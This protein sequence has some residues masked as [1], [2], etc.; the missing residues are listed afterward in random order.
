MK[1]SIGSKIINGPW[2]GGNLFVINLSNYLIS[3]GHQVI[4]DLTQNDIDII[5]LTDPRPKSD[6]TSKFNH[7][8][9]I[10]YKKFVNP[11][12][13]VVQRI[14]EC[15]E[16]KNTSGIN[17]FY[18]EASE[19]ANIVVFVSSWLESIYLK[20]GLDPNKSKVIMSGSN[21]QIFTNHSKNKNKNNNKNKYKLVTH[22]WSAH[23]NKG[24]DIY[25]KIDKMLK[26]NYW[27]DTIEFTYIGNVP[28]NHEFQNTNI[29]Q[30]LDGKNLAAELN[31]HNVYVTG[32]INEPSG[33][34]H[35]EAAL[36]GLP[37]VYRESGG[38]PE[39]CFGYGESFDENFESSLKKLIENYE[40]YA[41]NL[42]KYPFKSDKMCQEFM[43]L[44]NDLLSQEN[45]GEDLEI[46]LMPS[47]IFRSRQKVLDIYYF[48]IKER[49]KNILGYTKTLVTLR[50]GADG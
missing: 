7:K 30:P 15:D 38:L 50:R 17:N 40:F 26:D 9:I 48:S 46:P 11:N 42:E 22:H 20:M 31:L 32:S 3:K 37:M 29:I 49:L 43:N 28:K 5:L 45:L 41:K 34:H 13:K 21:E 33:N 4:F 47:I 19:S 2:G 36:C 44:F 23:Q 25:Y 27:K 6:S 10:N 16:R 14:N 8:D 18:L 12:V 39:Y 35:I 1:I 24:F